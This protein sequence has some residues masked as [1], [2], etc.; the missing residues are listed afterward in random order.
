MTG[1]NQSLGFL[2]RSDTKRS[3]QLQRRW[4]KL[5]ILDLGRRGVV[6]SV[7]QKRRCYSCFQFSHD[8]AQMLVDQVNGNFTQS[9]SLKEKFLHTCTTALMKQY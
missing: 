4:P 3:V 2:T 7:E 5:E 8:N 1:E 6:L 9:I